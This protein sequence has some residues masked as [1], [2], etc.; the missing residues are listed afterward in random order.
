MSIGWMISMRINGTFILMALLLVAGCVSGP[1]KLSKMSAFETAALAFRLANE[2]RYADIEPLMTEPAA[3]QVKSQGGLKRTW[4]NYTR[5][6]TLD[7]V[8]REKEWSKR[9]DLG[10]TV[11]QYATVLLRVH[12]AKSESMKLYVH[13]SRIGTGK[14]WQIALF[15]PYE[16]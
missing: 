5:E 9:E 14:P 10:L 2:G 3:Q 4:D 15:K 6:R 1:K 13:L 7:R 16:E 11:F 12:Y 8:V